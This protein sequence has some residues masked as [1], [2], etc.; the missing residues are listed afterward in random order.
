MPLAAMPPLISM[1]DLAKHQTMDDCWII[2]SGKAYD[3]TRWLG[4]HPG[5]ALPILS[6][7]GKDATDVFFNNHPPQVEK[8]L[9]A[10]FVG[11]VASTSVPPFV[12]DYRKLKKV[13]QS[14]GLFEITPNAYLRKFAVLAVLFAAVLWG[15]LFTSSTGVHMAAAVVLG[16][17]WQQIA[18]IGH[19]AGHNSVTH[20]RDVDLRIGFLVGNALTGIGMAWWKRTHNVHH[21]T[22]NSVEGDPDIQH[23]PLLAVSPKLF[24]SVFS[25]YH[26]RQLPFDWVGRF[27]VGWQHITFYPIMMVARVNLYAQSL[28]LALSPLDVPHRECELLSLAFFWAWF[29]ALLSFLPSP[30]ER[31]VFFFISHAIAGVLHIQICC[32]HFPM[33]TFSGDVPENMWCPKQLEGTLN[34]E[35]PPM[36]DWFFGGL[37]FQI[38][39]HL[40]P[41]LP[42]HNLRRSTKLVKQFC[43]KHSLPYTSVSFWEANVRMVKVLRHAALEA[44][45]WSLPTPKLTESLLWDGL[46]ARG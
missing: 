9:P 25:T 34:I 24:N 14:D 40:F 26:S 41:R 7:A 1:D 28:V 12:S 3:L 17:F 33:P 15:V 11:N 13:L 10:F 32:S 30:Q 8:M 38:E 21:I 5:G 27:L 44:R 46:N 35:C 4:K 39:H 42:R 37:Q 20:N 22:C 43:L 45:D 2:I 6:L 36:L 29:S 31:V 18:F 23:L 16:C 19:D